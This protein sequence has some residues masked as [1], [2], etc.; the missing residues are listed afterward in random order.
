MLALAL[1]TLLIAQTPA[2]PLV[3]SPA[4]QKA[5]IAKI[6]QERAAKGVPEK[7][8]GKPVQAKKSDKSS[9]YRAYNA[10]FQNE[11]AREAAIQREYDKKM[12]P[13]VAEQMRQQ[14]QADLR[15]YEANLRHQSNMDFNDA[16]RGVTRGRP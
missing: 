8:P 10:R 1:T 2:P 4:E 11:Q 14:Q 9:R 7:S 12:A 5:L 16:L 6:Q 15:V 3:K 13:I